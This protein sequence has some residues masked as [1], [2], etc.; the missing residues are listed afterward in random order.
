MR[1]SICCPSPRFQR[2][3][4]GL[5][6]SAGNRRV[7]AA[8]R[9]GCRRAVGS[10]RRA[11][12]HRA[13]QRAASLAGGR[14]LHGGEDRRLDS[15]HRD[16]RAGRGRH[17]RRTE[18]G[19][20]DGCA[21]GPVRGRGTDRA[22]RHGG[23]CAADQLPRLAPGRVE[24]P[25]RPAGRRRH[26]WRHPGPARRGVSDRRPVAGAVGIRDLRQ[27]L[28][29][30][31]LA[32]PARRSAAG[33]RS[34]SRGVG[35]V[36]AQR[37]GGSQS[38]LPAAEEDARCGD[39]DRP[40]RLRRAAALHLLH[41]HV[42]GRTRGADGRAALPRRLRRRHR[43][44]ADRQLL[45]ADA[46]AG[47]D[48]NPR[49][50]AGPLGH[51]R[52]DRRDSRRVPASVRRAR[53]PDR[54]RRQQLRRLPRHFRRHP[55]SAE[56]A[57]VGREAVPRQRRSESGGHERRRLPHRRADL[58]ARVRLQPLPF[59]DAAGARPQD[60]RHVGAEHRSVRQRPHRRSALQGTGR[61]GAGRADAR[62]PRRPRRH[63]LPD[64]GSLG[65][66]AR[67]CRRRTT[68]SPP[69]GTVGRPRLDRPGLAPVRAP[70]RQDD[71]DDRHRR[72]ARLARRATRLLPGRARR[73]G[74]AGRRRLRPALRHPAGQSRPHGADRRRRRR[75]QAARAV[76]SPDAVRAVRA[77]RRL[78]R[79]PRRPGPVDHAD[80]RRNR[81]L[82]LC[83]YPM[84]PKYV[85]GDVASSTSYRCADR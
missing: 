70:R 81:T 84:Y 75:R 21:A 16:R 83:S 56:P 1:H 49:E 7:D 22:D 8:A 72:H 45:L 82:P 71:R 63:R 37:R 78:G 32:R 54:R 3:P 19:G 38:R 27:R 85:G 29:T 31:S 77:P 20:R 44:R 6:C 68:E 39:G 33:R 25:R 42:P 2:G 13:I 66:P 67:L 73:D 43:Q 62:P 23:E 34:R 4:R 80:G 53:R 11:A 55:G 17:A 58:D 76:G 46:R 40:A 9:S 12:R 48:S 18:V 35:R 14:R 24:S 30:S 50:A 60:V 5:Q 64:A 47:V 65:E 57:A 79:T 10:A 74:P 51:A 61:R 41:G 59:L 26:E 36:G 28:G 69:R 52:E 15:R